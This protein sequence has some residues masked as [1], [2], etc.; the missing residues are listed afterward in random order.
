MR[1]LLPPSETKVSGGES[2]LQA[3]TLAFH[4]EL[5][6]TR[7]RVRAA[8]EALSADED[9]AI[10][11]LKLGTKSRSE[12]AH[13]LVLATSGV[14]PAIERYTGVLY[15]A[16][17]LEELPANAR[18]WIDDHVLIQSALFG[19]VSAQNHIPAYRLSASTRLPIAAHSARGGPKP[20]AA[21]SSDATKP[22][23]AVWREAHANID[24]S[25]LGWVLD[26]R[27]SDYAALA[28]MPI[29]NCARV[30]V[31]TRASDGAVRALNHFNKAAKGDLLHRLARTVPAID[32]TQEFLDWASGEGLECEI[33]SPV[34]RAGKTQVTAHVQTVRLV[35]G[36][37]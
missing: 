10:R 13:N 29:Q 23:A 4:T 21:G 9:R 1:V 19:L 6:A 18:E 8:L 27:S 12:L 28:P 20:R 35:V 33:A 36:A 26:M 30:D 24:W 16:I 32:S 2:R 15:D 3:E 7:E 34:T 11:A 31:V 37:S 25:A 22:L 17:K 5:G 14:M